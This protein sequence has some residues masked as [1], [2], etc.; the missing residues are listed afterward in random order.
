[1]TD[2][3][4][5]IKIDELKKLFD[6]NYIYSSIDSF[7]DPVSYWTHWVLFVYSDESHTETLG[8]VETV[9]HPETG[10]LDLFWSIKWYSLLHPL[11]GVYT[12]LYEFDAGYN[13]TIEIFVDTVIHKLYQQETRKNIDIKKKEIMEE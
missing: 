11:Q 1:M 12:P 8:K 3:Q 2:K 7:P 9:L 6:K 10:V 4:A 5:E 13:D